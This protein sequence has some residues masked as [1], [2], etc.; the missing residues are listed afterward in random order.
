[1]WGLAYQHASRQMLIDRNIEP[2]ETK[3]NTPVEGGNKVIYT[4]FE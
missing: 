1:M 3:L 2:I 4:F